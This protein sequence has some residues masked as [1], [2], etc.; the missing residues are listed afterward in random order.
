MIVPL[1]WVGQISWAAA[2][3]CSE[4][5]AHSTNNNHQTD[6]GGRKTYHILFSTFL[7]GFSKFNSPRLQSYK[8]GKKTFNVKEGDKTRHNPQGQAGRQNVHQTHRRKD[9][10]GKRY[11]DV[12]VHSAVAHVFVVLS[13][14]FKGFKSHQIKASLRGHLIQTLLPGGWLPPQL[15]H[16]WVSLV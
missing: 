1:A 16:L 15:S 6:G 4:R 5:A 10:D 13:V 12:V 14:S 11:S 3:F 9:R 7:L 2:R 8:G